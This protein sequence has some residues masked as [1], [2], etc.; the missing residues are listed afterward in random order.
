MPFL[1]DFLSLRSFLFL[2]SVLRLLRRAGILY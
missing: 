1:R 2:R